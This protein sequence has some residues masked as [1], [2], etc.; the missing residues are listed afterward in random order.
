VFSGSSRL[1]G[2]S[3]SAIDEEGKRIGFLS[4]IGARGSVASLVRIAKGTTI[5]KDNLVFHWA[6]TRTRVYL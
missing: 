5:L 6:V 3:Y 4:L 1:S 2:S